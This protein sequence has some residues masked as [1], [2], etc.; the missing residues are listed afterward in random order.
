M[1]FRADFVLMPRTEMQFTLAMIKPGQVYTEPY[2]DQG[3]VQIHFLHQIMWH[4]R[5][6]I[7]TG[8]R[9][10]QFAPSSIFGGWLGVTRT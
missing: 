8:L 5:C 7:N 1:A 10:R 9:D 6:N 4:A 3:S 2:P